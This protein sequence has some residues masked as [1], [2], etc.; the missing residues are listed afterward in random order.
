VRASTIPLLILA[1]IVLG[2]REVNADI[3]YSLEDYPSLQNGYDLQGFITTDGTFGTSITNPDIIKAWS[4][5]ILLNGVPQLTFS[6][7]VPGVGVE[8]FAGFDGINITPTEITLASMNSIMTLSTK[9][10][11]DLLGY[12]NVDGSYNADATISGVRSL[13]WGSSEIPQ[14]IAVAAVPEPSTLTIAGVTAVSCLVTALV[15]KRLAQR[16]QGAA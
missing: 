7:N 14:V 6:E 15:R 9:A 3:T 12:N 11:F 8:F 5:T 4:V 13:L 1:G 10:P 2:P 16:L